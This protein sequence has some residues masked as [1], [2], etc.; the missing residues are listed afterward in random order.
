[1]DRKQKLEQ[2]SFKTNVRSIRNN[3]R[4]KLTKEDALAQD[5]LDDDKAMFE[6]LGEYLSNNIKGGMTYW[7]E[8]YLE[9]KAMADHYGVPDYFL[10]LSMSD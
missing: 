1:M 9:L 3:D 2:L 8:Q 6:T 10:T 5:P 7:H 4:H